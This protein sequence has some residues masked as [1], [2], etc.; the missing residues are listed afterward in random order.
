MVGALN[1]LPIAVSGL[2]FF[3]AERSVVN[4]GSILSILIAFASGIVYS[5]AQIM[6][7]GEQKRKLS[8]DILSD[9]ASSGSPPANISVS[10]ST[11]SITDPL[12]ANSGHLRGGLPH[13]NDPEPAILMRSVRG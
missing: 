1:K 11:V 8:A 2:I 3:P 5:V 10:E 6:E 9:S 12:V 4:L 7:R 13:T